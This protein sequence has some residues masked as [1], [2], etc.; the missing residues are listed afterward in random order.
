MNERTPF[1]IIIGETHISEI[2]IATVTQLLRELKTDNI[3]V[4]LE[5][6]FP[7]EDEI[8]KNE[9]RLFELYKKIHEVALASTNADAF[10]DNTH[11]HIKDFPKKK[12]S[13]LRLYGT[14]GFKRQESF[15]NFYNLAKT[16]GIKFVGIDAPQD[17]RHGSTDIEI[18]NSRDTYMAKNLKALK[19]DN[20]STITIV[21]VNHIQR[22]Y[23]HLNGT[24]NYKFFIINDNRDIDD[25]AYLK[26]YFDIELNTCKTVPLSI[27]ST[28]DGE[29]KCV[30]LITTDNFQDAAI[31]INNLA[32]HLIQKQAK[33]TQFFNNSIKSPNSSKQEKTNRRFTVE[34]SAEE[35]KQIAKDLPGCKVQ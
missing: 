29:G 3:Y 28:L 9:N 16:K 15:I 30:H 10:V 27:K 5:S 17:K 13:Q 1:H 32:Q 4:C 7:T 22:L 25:F 24:G 11:E 20:T 26:D 31:E 23:H 14:L 2:A 6:F 35:I 8:V 21:G 34:L 18:I 33:L 12:H 19:E